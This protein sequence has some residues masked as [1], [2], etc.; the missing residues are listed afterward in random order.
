M[1]IEF[2]S[3]NVVNT[4]VTHTRTSATDSIFGVLLNDEGNTFTTA[5]AGR[6]TGVNKL[7]LIAL[8]A[9]TVLE[10]VFL[11]PFVACTRINTVYFDAADRL[12]VLVLGKAEGEDSS[13]TVVKIESLREP[14]STFLVNIIGSQ[15]ERVGTAQ[16]CS[17][18][19]G[20]KL[21]SIDVHIGKVDR[22]TKRSRNWTLFDDSTLRD[23]KWKNK[24]RNKRQ[25]D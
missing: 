10:R 16:R 13:E 8:T 5:S 11:A 14:K 1:G 9:L 19:D 23:G 21:G 3:Q 24:Q 7:L 2:N 20:D 17:C 15:S 22:I 6:R 4:S 25:N 18:T 12:A